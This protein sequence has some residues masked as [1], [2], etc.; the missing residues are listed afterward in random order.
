MLALI[1]HLT[2]TEGI[3]V[4]E[5]FRMAKDL[6]RRYLL[7]EYIDPSDPMFKKLVRGRETLFSSLSRQAFEASA[8]RFFDIVRSQQLTP[9]RHLYVMVKR[10]VH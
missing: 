10:N 4:S 5:I 9:E 6:T 8:N 2:A 7:I 1:H 3:P